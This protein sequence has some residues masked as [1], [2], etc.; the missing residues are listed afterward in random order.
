MGVLIFC[1]LSKKRKE[2]KSEIKIVQQILIFNITLAYYSNHI[3]THIVILY[4]NLVKLCYILLISWKDHNVVFQWIEKEELNV[5]E[6]PIKLERE[7][8]RGT[9]LINDLYHLVW[10]VNVKYE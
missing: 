6:L 7:K 4:I 3:S 1:K 5:W 10:F 8:E 2:K 9:K